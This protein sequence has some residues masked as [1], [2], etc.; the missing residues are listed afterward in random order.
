MNK[1]SIFF[2]I[3]VSFIISFLLLVVSFIVLFTNNYEEYSEQAF[4]KYRSLFKMLKKAKFNFS[5]N[6]IIN[7]EEMNYKIYTKEYDIK[8]FKNRDL[9]IFYERVHKKYGDVF[10]V[11]K[12][13]K[14]FY[15]YL[16]T[17]NIEILLE[18]KNNPNNIGQIYIT[19]VFS[20]LLITIILLHL[21]TWRRLI[22][23]KILQDKVKNLGD[24]NF[25]FDFNQSS[26][27]DEISQLSLEF[28]KSA[29]K[30]KN[31]K[32]ARN[33]FI[34][35]IMHELKTPITKGKILTQLEQ[36]RQNNEKLKSV[37]DRLEALINEFATI[38]ELIASTNNIEK[39]HY[40][41]DDIIDNAKDILMLE[42][43]NVICEYENRKLN[44]NFKL[45]SIAIKNLIDNGIKYSNDKKVTIKNEDE[46]II[47]ENFGEELK[48]PFSQYVEPFYKNQSKKDSFG[49]GLYIVNNILKA[50]GYTLKYEHKNAL[51]RFICAKE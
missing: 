12:D 44:V 22:P 33:I 31:L 47:I 19:L 1:Q 34:R 26:S 25:D 17:N 18:D 41:L 42:D 24:E 6:L 7:L 21:I 9:P 46:S 36:N 50:N 45:F 3:I 10:R 32:E 48:E 40:F 20:I 2:T 38:E 28:Q 37:F 15:I 49:L 14:N 16:N 30:L 43:D 23:L 29:L 35:N 5:D 39:K 8:R 51:N 27:K 4:N 13:S 11:L